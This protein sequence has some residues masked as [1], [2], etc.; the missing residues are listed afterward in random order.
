LNKLMI[1]LIALLFGLAP[2]ISV[3]A[4]DDKIPTVT[5][6]KEQVNRDLETVKKELKKIQD[7]VEKGARSEIEETKKSVK[8]VKQE[9]KN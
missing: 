3:Q 8:K 9:V 4:A 5:E 6:V 1:I 2:Y 7:A